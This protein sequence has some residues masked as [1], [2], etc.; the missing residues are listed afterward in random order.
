MNS[1]DVACESGNQKENYEN[2]YASWPQV[3]DN[4]HQCYRKEYGSS[5]RLDKFQINFLEVIGPDGILVGGGAKC[6][7]NGRLLISTTSR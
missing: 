4:S 1:N 6:E 3:I 5:L 7:I 2:E